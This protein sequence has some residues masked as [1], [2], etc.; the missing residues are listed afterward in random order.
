MNLQR[1][2][3]HFK[4]FFGFPFGNRYGDLSPSIL[5]SAKQLGLL[6]KGSGNHTHIDHIFFC[7]VYNLHGCIVTVTYSWVFQTAILWGVGGRIARIAADFFSSIP[8][9]KYCM[10]AANSKHRLTM[11]FYPSKKF[12]ITLYRFLLY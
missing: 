3:T 10:S 2:A 6:L 7:H 11:Y 5:P 4:E 8:F 1:S 12:Q 9:N